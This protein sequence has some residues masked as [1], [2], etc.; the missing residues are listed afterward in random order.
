MSSH[1]FPPLTHTFL[2]LF[3]GLCQTIP[4]HLYN[5]EGKMS[6]LLTSILLNLVNKFQCVD[7]KFGSTV[8]TINS[9][10][11]GTNCHYLHL[12]KR[13]HRAVQFFFVS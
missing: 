9:G 5:K 10:P 6:S 11:D 12:H 2:F 8:L 3:C 7:H 1:L 13:G 4:F